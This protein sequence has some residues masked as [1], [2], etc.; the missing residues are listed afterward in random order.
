M[1]DRRYQSGFTIY[2]LMLTVAVAILLAALGVP[3]L[4]ESIAN[5]RAT[6][7]TND[8]VTTLNLARSEATRRRVPIT[9]CASVD[10]INCSGAADW[11]SGWVIRSAAGNLIQ[12]WP[13]LNSPGILN[14]NVNSIQ[15]EPVGSITAGA[16]PQFALQMPKCNGDNRRVL[17]ISAAGRIAVDTLT[18]T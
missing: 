1:G 6:T 14:G 5:N 3:A 18:C 17:T 7:Y 2:E 12:A 4:N 10:S 8:M 15:F 16:A 9:V 11:S 13:A